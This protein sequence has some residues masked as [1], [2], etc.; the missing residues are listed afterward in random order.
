MDQS[1]GR[2]NHVG[3]VALTRGG[4]DNLDRGVRSQDAQ[5]GDRCTAR[6]PIRQVPTPRRARST[7]PARMLMT[8]RIVHRMVHLRIAA[9]AL[10]CTRAVVS[11]RTQ[12]TSGS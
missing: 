3:A 12:S 5:R 10:W 9:S 1:P 8:I 7:V 6:P 2:R 4:P 11:F